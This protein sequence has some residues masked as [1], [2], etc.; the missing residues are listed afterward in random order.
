MDM[1]AADLSIHGEI[2]ISSRK[3]T[4]C[5]ADASWYSNMS[6]DRCL[7]NRLIK[8]YVNPFQLWK[9]LEVQQ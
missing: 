5:W 3:F 1:S 2:N 8:V 7:P 9:T 6:E 4:I